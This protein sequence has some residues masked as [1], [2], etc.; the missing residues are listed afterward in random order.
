MKKINITGKI[1]FLFLILFSFSK[2]LA[3]KCISQSIAKDYLDSGV[4]AIVSI[5]KTY[6][7]QSFE[8]N[9]MQVNMYKADV[10]FGKI[11]KGEKFLSLN[12]YGTT[13]HSRSGAC[14]KLVRKGEKYLI[15]LDKNQDGQYFVSSCSPMIKISSEAEIREYENIFAVL[16][17]NR[18]KISSLEF[19]QYD[20]SS[21][22]YNNI[23]KEIETDFTNLKKRNLTGKVGIYKITVNSEG[24]ISS[25]FPI[26][27]IGVIEQ[28]IQKLIKKNLIIYQGFENKS[29]EY[30]ILLKL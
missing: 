30:L 28:K 10:V 12:I 7:N 27:K 1:L 14:E 26:Q 3:C 6:E 13:T 9:G 20:D 11:Y 22:V 17:K 5:D 4:V 8:R 18:T 25:V 29:S 15:L 21:E 24:R 2:G 19:V 23:K 16:E